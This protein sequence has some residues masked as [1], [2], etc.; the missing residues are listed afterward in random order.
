MLAAL[1]SL[2]VGKKPELL[3]TAKGSAETS[4]TANTGIGTEQLTEQLTAPSKKMGVQELRELLWDS[5]LER[6]HVTLDLLV[7]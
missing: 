3:P 7:T 1:I 5:F 4:T 6:K 2:E